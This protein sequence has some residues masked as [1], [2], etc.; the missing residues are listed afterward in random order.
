LIALSVSPFIDRGIIALDSFVPL[1][2]KKLGATTEK[3]DQCRVKLKLE[4]T[5]IIFWRHK[6]GETGRGIFDSV[7]AARLLIERVVQ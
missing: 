4:K 5:G 7:Q 1:L 6:I 2:R 3:N